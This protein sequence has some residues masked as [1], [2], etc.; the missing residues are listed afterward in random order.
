MTKRIEALE[1]ATTTKATNFDWPRHRRLMAA[2][3][4]R[5]DLLDLARE[6]ACEYSEGDG[7][8][9]RLSREFH[10]QVAELQLE[11]D[12]QWAARLHARTPSGV[13]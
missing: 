9:D 8:E 6:C 2:I 4:D 10:R 5:P 12:A 3:Q 13:E 11:L 1:R 7:R